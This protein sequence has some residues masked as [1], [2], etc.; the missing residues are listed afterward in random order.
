MTLTFAITTDA[1]T[2]QLME[3]G[4]FSFWIWLATNGHVVCF[5][6][7]PAQVPQKCQY[8]SF[9]EKLAL[10]VHCFA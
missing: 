1:L 2:R 5:L 7:T 9:F 6:E 4:E 10:F 8:W 3:C